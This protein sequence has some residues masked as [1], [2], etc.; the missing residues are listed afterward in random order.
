MR[1]GL[2]RCSS[3]IP[4]FVSWELE[5]FLG[6]KQSEIQEK[7]QEIPSLILDLTLVLLCSV[8]GG[9]LCACWLLPKVLR[10]GI[11]SM[12]SLFGPFLLLFMLFVLV[13]YVAT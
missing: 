13:L 4:L 11:R 6:L 12:L 9:M 3:C 2:V 1:I 8:V 10:P 5:A 7:M